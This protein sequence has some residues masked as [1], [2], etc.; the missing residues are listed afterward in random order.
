[1]AMSV[2][3]GIT[4]SQRDLYNKGR[5]VPLSVI[6]VDPNIGNED[7]A[8]VRQQLRDD[9]ESEIRVAVTRAGSMNI[10]TVGISNR[11]LQVIEAQNF[12][13]DEI[14]AVF[15]GGIPWRSD[16]FLSGDGLREANKQVKEVVIHPLHKMISNCRNEMFIGEPR[17]LMK[18]G[19]TLV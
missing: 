15:M 11:D 4:T 12:N 2:Y 9:W 1:M 14:D 8:I 16:Q 10:G 7:F 13:R 3:G 5:G 17:P 19:W 6:S 18:Q